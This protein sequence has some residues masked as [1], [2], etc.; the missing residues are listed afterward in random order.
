M[1][2][3]DKTDSWRAAPGL[4]ALVS[5]AGIMTGLGITRAAG[6]THP[7]WTDAG[8]NL[9]LPIVS[10]ILSCVSIAT[11]RTNAFRLMSLE[12]LVFGSF[13]LLLRGG[14]AVGFGGGP[15]PEVVQFDRVAAAFRVGVLALLAC[16]ENLRWSRKTVAIVVG[17][18]CGLLLV[19]L[20]LSFFPSPRW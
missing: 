10:L 6:C 20:K 12:L 11:T 4:V 3:F 2:R 19:S 16:D 13:F 8:H 7:W 18:L 14:Y 9:A 15:E 1:F 17:V 5:A